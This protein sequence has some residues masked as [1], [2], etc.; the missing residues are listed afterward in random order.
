MAASHREWRRA[1]LARRPPAR[2]APG[3]HGHAPLARV[4]NPR[5]AVPAYAE[6][7]HAKKL[8]P[9]H[10][11]AARTA[12][13]DE[14]HWSSMKHP[15]HLQ[16]EVYSHGGWWKA[17]NGQTGQVPDAQASR[18]PM[19]TVAAVAN[20]FGTGGWR[21]TD[22]VSAHHNTYLLSFEASASAPAG[23]SG[24]DRQ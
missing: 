22:L 14:H 5:N 9:R 3:G 6:G 18:S 2:P 20:T 21:L 17:S 16:V 12:G 23:T 24:D 19:A 8:P 15:Q 10:T 11:S 7:Y 13:R 1:M 4:A